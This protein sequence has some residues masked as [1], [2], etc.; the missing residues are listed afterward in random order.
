MTCRSQIFTGDPLLQL[1]RNETPALAEVRSAG[2][3][4][5]VFRPNRSA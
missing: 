5:T 2:R 3:A 4:F 1:M